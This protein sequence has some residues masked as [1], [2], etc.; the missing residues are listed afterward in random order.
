MGLPALDLDR[1]NHA[2]HV[3]QPEQRFH[4]EEQNPHPNSR[5]GGDQRLY[6]LILRLVC[7][8]D[9]D[10]ALHRL[11]GNDGGLE[12]QVRALGSYSKSQ[13]HIYAPKYANLAADFNDDDQVLPVRHRGRADL[14]VA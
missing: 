12:D 2:S 11:N 13:L 5:E 4:L 10:P 1:P 8:F 6:R 7:E 3:R 14:R 9:P